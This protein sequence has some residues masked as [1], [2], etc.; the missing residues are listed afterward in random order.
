[1]SRDHLRRNLSEVRQRVEA[2]CARSGRSAE[3]VQLVAVTK[4]APEAMVQELL[5]LGVCILGE[6][7]PQQLMERAA[8]FCPQVQW[9]LIGHLQ[10]NKVRPILPLVTCIHSIDSLRLLERVAAVAAELQLRPRVLLEVNVSGE[11]TKDGFAA[12]VLTQQWEEMQRI[13]NMEIAGLMTMAPHD[14]EPNIV[15]GCFR[16]LRALRDQ[17]AERSTRWKLPELSMGMSDDFEIAIEE[18]ATMIRLGSAL[19]QE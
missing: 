11:S 9:H 2:A 1:M 17:L 7:R 12:D 13:E 5:D 19:F 10:R 6:S 15:R 4:Y 8:Q 16:Q 14:T 18:G 3:E